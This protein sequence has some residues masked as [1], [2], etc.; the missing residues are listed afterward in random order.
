MRPFPKS[1]A[2]KVTKDGYM[3]MNADQWQW[4]LDWAGCKSD[5]HK[6]QKAAVK[7]VITNALKLSFKAQK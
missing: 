4:F 2:F 7:K 6:I 3:K 1:R 5:S